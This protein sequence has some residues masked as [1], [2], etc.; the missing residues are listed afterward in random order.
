MRHND[1]IPRVLTDEAARKLL[2][3]IDL[4]SFDD[5][6][7]NVFPRLGLNEYRRSINAAGHAGDFLGANLDGRYFV[8]T[9][10]NS[11]EMK[12]AKVRLFIDGKYYRAV[13]V[14]RSIVDHQN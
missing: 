2:G 8:L 7:H 3:V 5:V 11:N 12:N 1:F 10:D 4:D 14:K 9:D 13:E 6:F